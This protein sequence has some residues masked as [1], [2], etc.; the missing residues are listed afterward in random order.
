MPLAEVKDIVSPYGLLRELQDRVSLEIPESVIKEEELSESH[1]GR[2]GRYVLVWYLDAEQEAHENVEQTV[3]SLVKQVIDPSEGVTYSIAD[4][5]RSRDTSQIMVTVEVVEE[6]VTAARRTAYEVVPP[7]ALP[8]QLTFQD[9]EY[10]I[11]ST[12]GGETWSLMR[13]GEA[14]EEELPSVAFAL[15]KLQKHLLVDLSYGEELS[16]GESEEALL[17]EDQIDKDFI[18]STSEFLANSPL[19]TDE[20][21]EHLTTFVELVTKREFEPETD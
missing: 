7:M 11:E 14:V 5:S 13:N 18:V 2:I 3:K 4:V 6:P 19:V 10:K 21:L 15:G 12:D 16:T 17:V 9:S 8:F 1:D 20:A